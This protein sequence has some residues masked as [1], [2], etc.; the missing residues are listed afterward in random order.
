MIRLEHVWRSFQG[1]AAQPLGRE[2]FWRFMQWIWEPFGDHVG[3]FL[4]HFDTS[5]VCLEVI[6]R[7]CGAAPWQGSV[8]EVFELDF[9]PF[10]GQVE[11]FGTIL[12]TSGIRFGGHFKGLR[13]SPLAGK[14]FGGFCIG[15]GNILVTMWEA[16]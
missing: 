14:R 8:F 3:G 13:R 12:D 6:S 11:A 7:G 2:A 10:G 15:F 4:N 5:G 16:V 9:G 1:A